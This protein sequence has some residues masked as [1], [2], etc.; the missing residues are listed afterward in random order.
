MSPLQLTILSLVLLAVGLAMLAAVMLREQ[1]RRDVHTRLVERALGV[2]SQEAPHAPPDELALLRAPAW[3]RRWLDSRFGRALVAEED[4]RLISQS[5][6][7]ATR[8]QIAFLVARL[9]LCLTLPLLAH[10]FLGN[11]K[12]GAGQHVVLLATGFAMGYLLPKWVLKHLAARRRRQVTHELPLFVDLL[13][14]LQSVG[15]SLDQSLQVVAAEFQHVMPVLGAEVARANR[16]YAQGRSR[17][18]A[19][20][21]MAG[22]HDNQHLIDFVALMNQVDKHGGAVQEPIRQFGERLRVHRKAEMRAL[23][24]KITVKM[25]VVMVAT[26]LPALVIVTAGPGFIAIVRSLGSITS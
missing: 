17:E 9:L 7:P 20:Q 18:Q 1:A 12:G 4:R 11:G 3:P 25:T 22:L 10:A 2:H 21:R 14:L 8:A 5:G 19:Y 13:G 24:G 15:L 26:L 16:Q 6:L 23:V